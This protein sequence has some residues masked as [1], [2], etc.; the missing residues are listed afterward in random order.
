LRHPNIVEVYDFDLTEWHAPYY[1][2]EHLRGLSLYDALSIHEGPLPEE[3]TAF[4]LEAVSTGLSYAHGRGVVHRDLKPDNIFI[5]SYGGR[6][7]VRILDFGIAKVIGDE[8]EATRLTMT[9]TVMG[10]PRYLAPE[11]VFDQEIGPWTDQ[12]ALALIAAEMLSGRSPRAGK[13][14]GEILADDIRR[15]L[16][17]RELG[18]TEPEERIEAIGRASR[19]KMN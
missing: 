8:G 14:V 11:Q 16:N 6:A 18:L 4:I 13:T 7:A 17:A 12:Y 3:W 19:P 10:T 9:G 15:P 2:M 1:V 5:T